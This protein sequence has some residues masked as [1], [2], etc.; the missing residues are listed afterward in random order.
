MA[1]DELVTAH[2]GSMRKPLGIFCASAVLTCALV[3]GIHAEKKIERTLTIAVHAIKQIWT[4]KTYAKAYALKLGFSL[5]EWGCA[6]AI[7]V[8][9]S[10]WNPRARNSSSGAYGIPQALPANKMAVEGADWATNFQTQVRWY[11]R[12]LKYHWNNQP[13]LAL[14]Y[15]NRNNSY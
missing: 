13:C 9:E 4:P 2:T 3:V 12:Y 1:P 7:V 11:F 14:A 8:K 10:H 5:R 15:H 6:N